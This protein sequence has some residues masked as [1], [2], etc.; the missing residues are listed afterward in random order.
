MSHDSKR[1][2]TIA[3][4]INGSLL[5]LDEGRADLGGHVQ[6]GL[7]TRRP[8][9]ALLAAAGALEADLG[10]GLLH[11]GDPLL[12]LPDLYVPLG[13]VFYHVRSAF[14]L[15]A[16]SFQDCVDASSLQK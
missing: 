6:A 7:D 13:R 15:S 10:L 12:E 5:E 16:G 14:R 9:Q 8:V 3:I 1:T 2:I 11:V 4:V